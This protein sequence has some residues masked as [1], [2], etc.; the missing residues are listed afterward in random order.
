[1][2]NTRVDGTEKLTCELTI[3]DG[4]IVY[5]LNGMEAKLWNEPADPN[6]KDASKWTTFAPRGPDMHGTKPS[7]D[8]PRH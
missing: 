5:D 8:T 2:V 1:M 6:A 4:K 3:K 7:D